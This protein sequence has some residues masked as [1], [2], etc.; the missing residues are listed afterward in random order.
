MP[1]RRLIG[2]CTF[3]FGGTVTS[4]TF[5]CGDSSVRGFSISISA[6]R[7]F[8]SLAGDRETHGPIGFS[9]SSTKMTFLPRSSFLPFSFSPI[10]RFSSIDSACVCARFQDIATGRQDR[11]QQA[12]WRGK[13]LSSC[14][15][16]LPVQ[17]V[18]ALSVR[19]LAFSAS[20]VLIFG[21]EVASEATRET[22]VQT[23]P[24]IRH[25]GA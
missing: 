8:A 12:D 19:R 7:L 16:Q 5:A 22:P 3:G 6:P 15:C 24:G 2:R 20:G 10:P 14:Q 1:H 4:T 23:I 21:D 11:R 25:Y 13:F 18:R 17:V 9:P